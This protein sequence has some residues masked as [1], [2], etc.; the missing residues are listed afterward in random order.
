MMMTQE[1]TL[2]ERLIDHVQQMASHGFVGGA[3]AWNRVS[4][5]ILA[6]AEAL[7]ARP[8]TSPPK[9][10]V[11]AYWPR[12]KLDDEGCETDER[13]PGEWW[14]SK[15]LGDYWQGPEWMEWMDAYGT[16]FGDEYVWAHEPTHWMPRP[17]HP[18][19]ASLP[20]AEE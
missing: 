2:A 1:K 12:M 4:N 3:G 10:L 11:L 20:I 19:V 16:Y 6:A 17:D 5:D 18:P 15:F 7:K 13:L 9:G 14:P 8:I